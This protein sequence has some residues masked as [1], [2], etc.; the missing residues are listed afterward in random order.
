MSRDSVREIK[1]RDV[2]IGPNRPLV[3][4]CGPCV[5]ESEEHTLH[6]ARQLQAIFSAA[7]LPWIFKASYDKANRSSF[8]S[9]RGPGI[10]RGLRILEK[11]RDEIGVPV[12]SDI[13]AVTEVEAAAQVCDL[14]QIPAFLC[15]QTDLIVGAASSQ[16]PISIKKGQ[17]MAPMDMSNVVD[18]IE[19]TGN[20]NILLIERG[21][22]F[23]YNNLVCDMRSIP[24]M[25][26]LGVPVCFDATHAVQLPGGQGSSSGGQ[27]EFIPT[28]AYAAVAAG[29]NALFIEA[30]PDP[31]SAK[32]DAATV[33]PFTALP[34]LLDTL[35]R[36]YDALA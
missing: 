4:I 5:M 11:V 9:F 35:K 27:R 24:L 3:V 25:Q 19:S 8:A 34:K 17:F 6:C 10:D 29:C 16:L 31:S 1:I 30:H 12:T 26:Q 33:L 22:T 36:L 2:A 7:A 14:M 13:H 18:K 21:T 20:K 15:R 23:G 28:L 32:S